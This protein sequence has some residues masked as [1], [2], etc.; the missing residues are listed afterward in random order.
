MLSQVTPAGSNTDLAAV[1]E[2][3][4]RSDQ[5]ENLILSLMLLASNPL[6]IVFDYKNSGA[7]DDFIAADEKSV[8]DTLDSGASTT[9]RGVTNGYKVLT[10]DPAGSG[11]YLWTKSA[12]GTPTTEMVEAFA[13]FDTYASGSTKRGFTA[14]MEH[15]LRRIEDTSLTDVR[16]FVDQLNG[17]IYIGEADGDGIFDIFP[18]ALDIRLQLVR[19]ETPTAQAFE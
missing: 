18:T 8:W 16:V 4:P 12:V 19:L 1:Y 9:Y 10:P 5:P 17:E 2:P 11:K 7:S 14:M 6:Q 3:A 15:V 13:D